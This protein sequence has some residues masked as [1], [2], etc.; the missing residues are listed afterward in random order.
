MK[1]GQLSI[2]RKFP[3]SG[4]VYLR[5]MNLLVWQARYFP[6]QKG[7]GQ[8]E[9]REDFPRPYPITLPYITLTYLHEIRRMTQLILAGDENPDRIIILAAAPQELLWHCEK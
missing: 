6:A 9:Y 4:M 3:F 5:P 7:P 1:V 8:A 2:E